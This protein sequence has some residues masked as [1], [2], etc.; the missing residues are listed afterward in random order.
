MDTQADHEAGGFSRS[1]RKSFRTHVAL[2][3]A[4][5]CVMCLI[6]PKGMGW[7]VVVALTAVMMLAPPL[8]I[9]ALRHLKRKGQPDA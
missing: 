9:R 4:F 8:T 7:V 5:G 6:V 3:A 2:M 1:E